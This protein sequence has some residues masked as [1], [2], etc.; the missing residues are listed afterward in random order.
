MRTQ[1]FY[2]AVIVTAIFI[3]GQG[4]TDLKKDLPTPESGLLKVHDP[5]WNDTAAASF[6]GKVLKGKEYEYDGCVACHAKTF[7]GGISQVSCYKCHTA[8]PHTSGWGDI[9]AAN[10]H[11][12]YLQSQDWQLDSCAACHGNG[13]MGGSSGVSCHKCHTAFPHPDL[14]DTTFAGFRT[15]L[16]FHGTF[17]REKG[18]PLGQCQ[19]CHGTNYRGGEVQFSC[20]SPNC[21]VDKNGNAK[22]PEACNTCHGIFRALAGDTL[23]WAPPRSV[24][25]G[26]DEFSPGVGAHQAHLAEGE[27]SSLINCRQCH[28]VPASFSESGHIDSTGRAKLVFNRSLAALITGDGTLVPNPSYDTVKHVCNNTFCHGNWKARKDSAPL[29][30]QF[31]YDDSVITGKAKA[32]LWTGGGDEIECG[33]CHATPPKGHS[34]YGQPPT[35]TECFNC[36]YNG[37]VMDKTK[38]I[39]GRINV[40]IFGTDRNF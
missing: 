30:N 29:D 18:W 11:G 7:K 9:S 23:S 20:S 36:H 17:L 25:G 4:C 38:H 8:F 19:S 24:T 22:N 3:A 28:K 32:P 2:L 34:G 1:I 12:K 13:F 15:S 14:W 26:T 35:L 39:N 31:I 5:G 37:D 40:E 16:I 10:F 6:H 21:H 33:S 27:L